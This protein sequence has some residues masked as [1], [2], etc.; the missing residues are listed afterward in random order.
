MLEFKRKLRGQRSACSLTPLHRRLHAY[1]YAPTS[2]TDDARISSTADR[3]Q[4]PLHKKTGLPE[5]LRTFDAHH[6]R[7]HV[8]VSG[9]MMHFPNSDRRPD[10][11]HIKFLNHWALHLA[12]AETSSP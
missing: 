12:A 2:Q 8:G 3:N 4:T 10:R 1:V 7:L 6:E 11:I 9:P 5:E